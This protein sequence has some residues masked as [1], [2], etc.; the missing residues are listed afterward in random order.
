MT[1]KITSVCLILFILFA[2]GS[3]FAELQQLTFE[4][5]GMD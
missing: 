1:K 3:V 2:G 5:E 4:I